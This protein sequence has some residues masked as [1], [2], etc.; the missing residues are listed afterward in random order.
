M[1]NKFLFFHYDLNMKKLNIKFLF[2]IKKIFLYSINNKIK[3]NYNKFNLIYLEMKIIEFVKIVSDQKF[4][5]RILILFSLKYS[6]IFYY[7]FLIFKSKK[8]VC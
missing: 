2:N 3:W 7:K 1:E 4:L 8:D 5:S 6:K